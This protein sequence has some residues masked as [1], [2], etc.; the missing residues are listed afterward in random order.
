M[1]PGWYG[2]GSALSTW[3]GEDADRLAFLQKLHREWPFFRSVM[4]NMAQVMAKA[5]LAVAKMYAE[6]VPHRADAERIFEAIVTEFRLT[7]DM[8]VK[9]TGTESLLDD[10]PELAVSMRNRFPYLI[11]LNLIQLEL[12]RRY[13]AGDESEDV[14]DGIRLTMNGLATGLR[15]SG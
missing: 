15:N 7:L 1:L 3:V 14:L 6:L 8:Y 9:V 11:P 12:L 10:N 13:R 4:S 5:D 2:V